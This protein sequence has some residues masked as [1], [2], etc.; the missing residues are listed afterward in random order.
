MPR[1]ASSFNARQMKT[2]LRSRIGRL[3][4]PRFTSWTLKRSSVNTVSGRKSHERPQAPDPRRARYQHLC[5]QFQDA[6]WIKPQPANH[7]PLARAEEAA[8]HLEPGDFG[9]VSGNL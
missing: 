2:C 3:K 7:S 6:K 4:K 9:R 8:T 1:C 5:A